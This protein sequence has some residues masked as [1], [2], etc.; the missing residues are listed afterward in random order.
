[1][2]V[3]PHPN[4]TCLKQD[5]KVEWS[6]TKQSYSYLMSI[7]MRYSRQGRRIEALNAGYLKILQNLPSYKPE[8][9]QSPDQANHD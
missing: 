6:F 4:S 5:R 2:N 3:Q 8:I 7:C 1:M 9:F